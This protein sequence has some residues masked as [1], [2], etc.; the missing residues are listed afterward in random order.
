M[1][2]A[3]LFIALAVLVTMAITATG[4]RRSIVLSKKPSAGGGGGGDACSSC[5]NE[6]YE[7]TGTVLTG[8]KYGDNSSG[9][10]TNVDYTTSPAPLDGSQSL[11]IK[12]V[13]S[14]AG[15]TY[16]TVTGSSGGVGFRFRMVITNTIVNNMYVIRG[17]N[18]VFSA[19]F[20]VQVQSSGLRIV[21]GTA[22][23]TTVSTLTAGTT[24]YVWGFYNKGTGA[25][26]VAKVAFSTSK[27][28]PTSGNDYAAVSTGTA[29]NDC[30]D[31]GPWVADVS[32]GSGVAGVIYDQVSFLP[33]AEIGDFP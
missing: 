4:D 25:N 13:N 18:N 12:N 7:G 26:G 1:R 11:L 2:K 16:K 21:H 24:Y 31:L 5:T 20:S 3:S 14:Q 10:V 6:T 9:I 8:W 15:Y 33:G 27:T 29:T 32:F 28:K 22:N 30:V 17:Y 19:V 23:A